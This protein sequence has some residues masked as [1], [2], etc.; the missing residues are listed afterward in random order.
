MQLRPANVHLQTSRFSMYIHSGFT[1]P[2]HH[3]LQLLRLQ[4]SMWP[5]PIPMCQLCQ[6][7]LFSFILLLVTYQAP[8]PHTPNLGMDPIWVVVHTFVALYSQTALGT[9]F[10]VNIPLHYTNNTVAVCTTNRVTPPGIVQHE[11]IQQPWYCATLFHCQTFRKPCEFLNVLAMLSAYTCCYI[12]CD[13]Y[14]I[15]C[16]SIESNESGIIN[17]FSRNTIALR[18]SPTTKCRTTRM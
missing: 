9:H 11:V 17:H 8:G 12:P 16:R 15:R 1:V 5:L 13:M 6:K 14:W 3:R 18:T 2:T 7:H 4:C 10:S